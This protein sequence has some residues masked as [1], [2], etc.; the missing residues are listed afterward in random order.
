MKTPNYSSTTLA[1]RLS[2]LLALA[3]CNGGGGITTETDGSSSSGDT[4]TGGTSSSGDLPTDGAVT[5]DPTD[6]P[7]STTLVVTTTGT[8][9]DSTTGDSTTEALVTTSTGPDSDSTTGTS[10]TGDTTDTTDTTADTDTGGDPLFP[11]HIGEVGPIDP[12]NPLQYPFACRTMDM[13]LGLPE[14]DNDQGIGL[15]IK[16]A[17][18]QVIGYSQHCGAKTRVDYF[19]KPT[20]PPPGGGLLPY[21]PQSPPDDIAT[22]EIGGV[23][24]KYIVR[25]ERGTINRFVYGIGMIAPNEVDPDVPDTSAWN[26]KLIFWFGGGVGVGHQQSSGLAVNR[27]RNAVAENPNRDGPLNNPLLEQGYAIVYS[28]GTVTDTTYNLR[29]TG[30]T[31]EMVKQQ[32]VAMYGAPK[33]TFGIGGSGGAIQQ[34]IYEQNHPDLLDG[35]V[36]THTYTDMITQTIRIGDCE[37]L[38]RWFDV[39]D[40][41][42]PKWALW[43]NR[44]KIEGLNAIDGFTG[45]DWDF[46]NQGKPIGSSAG[47]GSS[48]CI[49]GWRG[50]TP[51]AMN[52]LWVDV[53]Q[54]S[55]AQIL[56]HDPAG[57]VATAWT[58]FDDLVDIF[59]VDPGSAKGYAR[60]TWDNVGVQYGLG[61]L[62]AGDI[63]TGEFLQLN[64]A[65]GG[66]MPPDEMVPEGFPYGT[67]DPAELDPWSARNGTAKLGMPVA[68]RTEGDIDAM[69]IAY[70]SGLVF[71]GK[72]DAPTINLMPYLEP[73]LDMHNA[74]QPFAVRRRIEEAHMG[75]HDNHVIWGLDDGDAE[76]AALALIAFETLELWLDAGQKPPAATDA[77][78]GPGLVEIAAGDDVWK[79]AADPDPDK[80]ACATAYPVFA[81]ARMVAGEDISTDTFKCATKPLATALA[82]GTYGAVVWSADELAKLEEIFGASG[83][84]DYT[85]PDLGR[86]DGI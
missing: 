82:D 32:F 18:D 11:V 64:A 4:S 31:A 57:F 62:V 37:L 12:G 52:P 24:H 75:S 3:A 74:K 19:Y 45:S 33:Y 30:R 81:D 40:A 13:D 17:D 28:S 56:E 84:C 47:P 16:D 66:Y 23:E 22:V 36:P 21:D 80:G 34:L 27:L 73:E 8:T 54:P 78:Y 44:Q 5:L 48:E 38:E 68:P 7:T 49:E 77:C 46:L 86:P 25:Y 61:A 72:I 41:A 85:L 20:V 50:L 9:D 6:G 83:V 58:Y 60:R 55:Y 26:Q 1:S 59:G 76:L 69:N 65:V 2:L 51:L 35:L 29:L 42:N 71:L 63:T 39:D 53:T 79:N 15:P 43:E 67:E 70:E 10:S 14:I